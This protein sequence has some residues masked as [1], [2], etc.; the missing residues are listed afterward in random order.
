MKDIIRYTVAVMGVSIPILFIGWMLAIP[1]LN[2][3]HIAQFVFSIIECLL[4]FT[5]GCIFLMF[6]EDQF[7][8]LISR[9]KS[10]CQ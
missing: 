2:N 3:I 6:F 1:V 10:K 5:I 4:P 8:K 9:N 7:Q